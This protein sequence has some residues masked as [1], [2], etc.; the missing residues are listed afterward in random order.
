MKDNFFK[1]IKNVFD[2]PPEYPY[3][4]KHWEQLRDRLQKV[5]KNSKVAIW[6]KYGWI[7]LWLLPFFLLGS[8]TWYQQKQ[9]NQKI[10]YLQN[11]LNKETN[12]D[13]IYQSDTLFN[14]VVI[15][16]YDTIYHTTTVFASNIVPTNSLET[17]AASIQ[18]QNTFFKDEFLTT[19]NNLENKF[20]DNSLSKVSTFHSLGQIQQLINE[21]KPIEE[22]PLK[23]NEEALKEALRE[24]DKLAVNP[25]AIPLRDVHFFKYL[26]PLVLL[27]QEEIKLLAFLRPT[28]L[29]LGV[30]SSLL[31]VIRNQ[32]ENK[33]GFTA[34]LDAEIN[35]GNQVSMFLGGEYLRVHYEL[36]E[37]DDISA[38]PVVEPENEQDALHSLRVNSNY[39][40]IPFGVKYSFSSYRAFKPYLG[41]GVVARRAI[42]KELNYEFLSVF[43][44]YYINRNYQN[45]EFAINTLR[46]KLGF[47]YQFHKHWNLYL[48]GTYDHD[49]RL[50]TADFEKVKYL[51]IRT[52]ILYNF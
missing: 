25:I 1:N 2:T 3:Q 31:R 15:N 39:L 9:A 44:E 37:E 33:R 45:N 41:I 11:A 12:K 10:E 27:Y 43:E 13:K 26:E 38:Y 50:S 42:R 18:Q 24:I 6:Q 35:F 48:E 16:Q 14:H 29:K 51:N 8:Y 17:D 47:D 52:G 19:L 40:Q 4:E 30:G 34:G 5:P 49:F 21:A 20:A 7:F 22:I 36:E 28:G 32:G 46:G 23:Y